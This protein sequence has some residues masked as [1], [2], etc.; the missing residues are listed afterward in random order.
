VIKPRGNVSSNQII[1]VPINPQTNVSPVLVIQQ[2]LNNAH[3]SQPS[4]T[5]QISA[6][7]QV[8][9]LLLVVWALLLYALLQLQVLAWP[10]LA[11]SQQESVTSPQ[12]LDVFQQQPAQIVSPPILAIQKFVWMELVSSLLLFAHQTNVQQWHQQTKTENVFAQPLQLWLVLLFLLDNVVRTFAIQHQENALFKEDVFVTITI[13][14]PQTLVLLWLDLLNAHSLQSLAQ[15]TLL[16]PNRFAPIKMELEFVFL[17]QE[18]MSSIALLQANV[19]PHNAIL[20]LDNVFTPRKIAPIQ[21]LWP[22]KEQFVMQH[23]E[24]VF[25]QVVWAALQTI[26][27][28]AEL[29]ELALS[30]MELKLA[31]SNLF[32]QVTIFAP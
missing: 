31:L 10:Q 25:K 5:L 12:F 17:I 2:I 8:V 13:L 23:L 7:L 22:V 18:Q 26:H 30:L 27:L 21:I 4:V 19:Q 24:H 14:A 28:V 3:K 11:I 9:I 15:E 20:A 6:L 1:F 29:M 32:A 16:A